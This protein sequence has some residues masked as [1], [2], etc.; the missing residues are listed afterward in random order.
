VGDEPRFL[1]SLPFSKSFPSFPL[2]GV[3]PFGCVF[4][5]QISLVRTSISWDRP[6]RRAKRNLQ[7]A[8]TARTRCA[9]P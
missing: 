7:R 3:L 6:G 4:F 1:L 9:P 2:S 8:A 5:C